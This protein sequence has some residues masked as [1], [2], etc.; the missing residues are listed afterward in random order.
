MDAERLLAD[1]GRIRFDDQLVQIADMLIAQR[2]R[3]GE[4]SRDTLWVLV[5]SALM[6]L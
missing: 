5:G 6:S 3:S 1:A 4:G 2:T